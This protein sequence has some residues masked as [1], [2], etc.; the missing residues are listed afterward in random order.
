MKVYALA[1]LAACIGV[2]VAP[3]SARER[4]AALPTS[5]APFAAVLGTTSPPIG[6]VQF[7]TDMPGECRVDGRAPRDVVM[8]RPRWSELFEVNRRVN[9]EV[10]PATDREVYGV[11]EH[12]TYPVQGRG[13]CEDY[14]LEKRRRLA[15]RGWPMSALLVTVVRDQNGDGHAVLTVRTT[16]GDFVLDNVRDEILPW[17]QTGYRFVKRQSQW[18]PNIWVSLPD[19][20]GRATTASNR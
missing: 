19:D 9:R 16:E 2:W 10:T 8:N 5:E 18:S 17:N 15:T 3:A 14:V 12:W 7:C 13:D 6:W 1:V 20:G 4:L 11:A